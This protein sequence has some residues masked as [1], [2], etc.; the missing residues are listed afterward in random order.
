MRIAGAAGRDNTEPCGGVQNVTAGWR[1]RLDR[2]RG[3]VV[4]MYR[5]TP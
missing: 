4:E 3:V 1:A 2:D 5:S